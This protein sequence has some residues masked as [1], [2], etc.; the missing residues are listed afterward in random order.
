MGRTAR[1]VTGIELEEGDAVIAMEA[2]APSEQGTLLTIC[3]HGYGKRTPMDEYRLQ[4]RGGK[5]IIT[6][7]TT[8]RNGPVM[9]VVQVEDRD[10]LMLVTNRGK[11]IRSA[12]KDIRVQGR[13]TQ[14]VRLISMEADE[15]VVG[16]A[17]LV[18][19]DEAN[20]EA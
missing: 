13:D 10:E 4:N 8:D 5:G 6:I 14:G 15:K 1:G 18:E 11:I 16:Q 20:G 17:R 7:K 2:L 3:E 12:V 9:A 19:Q